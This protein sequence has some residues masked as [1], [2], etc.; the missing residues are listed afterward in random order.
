MDVEIQTDRVAMC[1][2]WRHMIHSWVE[3]CRKHHPSVAGMD[4]TLRY[5][6]PTCPA[7]VEAVAT[8]RGRRL[9]AATRS[10]LVS[11]AL[12]DALDALEQELLVHE[13]V[14]RAA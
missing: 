4:V 8:A 11:V 6:G 3:R 13:A 14:S 9:R 10:I 12:H 1:P 2:E 5:E 7:E